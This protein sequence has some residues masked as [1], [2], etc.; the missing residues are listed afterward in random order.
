MGEL[1]E[2]QRVIMRIA[3]VA[4][5]VGW[6]ANVGAMETAGMIVSVLAEQPDLVKRF[7]AEGSALFIEGKIAAE[8]GRLT[9]HRMK[10]GQVT[11]PA[12][13]RNAIRIRNMERG[14]PADADRFTARALDETG[15]RQ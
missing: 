5:A 12:E 3:E 8:Y 10:D 14:L 4:E 7:L 6:Q 9:F 13:L 1:T 2:A 11:T 15:G